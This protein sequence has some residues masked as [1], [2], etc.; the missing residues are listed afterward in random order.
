MLRVKIDINSL[1]I[2]EI[3]AV[4]IEG[5][6]RPDSIG[7]YEVS[8]KNGD[9]VQKLGTVWHRYGDGALRLTEIISRHVSTNLT[10]SRAMGGGH[11]GK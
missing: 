11:V 1:P 2:S 7:V 5:D 4:R 8:F 6:T 10:L 3:Y 9:N